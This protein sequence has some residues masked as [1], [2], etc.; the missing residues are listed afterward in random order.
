ML[1]LRLKMRKKSNFLVP[2]RS[3]VRD[4]PVFH[5]HTHTLY[6]VICECMSP[7]LLWMR[8]DAIPTTSSSVLFLILIVS[9]SSFQEYPLAHLFVALCLFCLSLARS[10]TRSS[11]VRTFATSP[12]SFKR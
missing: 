8:R 5:T 12:L 11:C 2:T 7:L 3:I 9:T 6:A 4:N 10:L 1:A